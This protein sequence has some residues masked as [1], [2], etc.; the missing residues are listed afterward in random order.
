[1]M[2]VLLKFGQ[3]RPN[4]ILLSSSLKKGQDK[5]K[6]L[7]HFISI[8]L[9]Q[10]RPN[11]NPDLLSFEREKKTKK[12]EEVTPQRGIKNNREYLRK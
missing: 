2:Y 5:A 10:K 1:M 12:N 3:N 9:F 11:D 6:C 7:I 4:K 8:K